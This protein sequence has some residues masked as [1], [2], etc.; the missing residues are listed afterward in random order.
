M[1]NAPSQSSSASPISAAPASA[2][3]AASLPP[4]LCAI[5][6]KVLKKSR[7]WRSER[8]DVE[9]ELA[10]HFRD[11]L[12]SGTAP[13]DLAR[14]FGD[15]VA[16][17]RLIRR[18]KLRNRPLWWRTY[19]RA[20]QVVAWAFLA[21]VAYTTFHVL[22]FYMGQPTLRFKPTEV[23]NR[24]ALATPESKR[25]WP[26]YR[27]AIL[28][29]ELVFDE[30][31]LI[32]TVTFNAPT[33]EQ[34]EQIKPLLARSKHVLELIRQA[35]ALPSLGYVASHSTDH[36]IDLHLWELNGKQ[37]QPPVATPAEDPSE[38]RNAIGILFPHVGQ[39]RQLTRL[40]RADSYAAMREGDAA[41]FEANLSAIL[42]LSHQIRKPDALIT[43]LVAVAIANIPGELLRE[44]LVV[45]PDL[46]KDSQLRDL[47]HRFAAL[48]SA[49][50]FVSFRGE[51]VFF[52]DFLQRSYTDDGNGN[53]RFTP[54]GARYAV[55]IG[56]PGHGVPPLYAISSIVIADRKELHTLYHAT[57]DRAQ[58]EL[59][60]PPWQVDRS[61]PRAES[62]LDSLS[63]GTLNE[64]RYEAISLLLP[65]L[66]K[67]YQVATN[68]VMERDA[69][70]TAIAI[71]LY[72]RRSGELPPNLEA[73]VPSLLPS[74]PLDNADGQP[75]RY[76][77]QQGGYMLY[78][79]GSD[80]LDAGG[81]SASTSND[82]GKLRNYTKAPTLAAPADWVFIPREKLIEK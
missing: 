3:T 46:L 24:D 1:S 76:R 50:D 23:M 27:R 22:R 72:R 47:A 42:S 48:G 26:L 61:V 60:I 77:K 25:A 69:T 18:G 66:G 33:D 71:E 58:A 78:S 29:G 9:A 57:L 44:S 8:A 28:S 12:D 16:A 43:N 11:G 5:V 70:L 65:A 10:T 7:L 74:L 79:L 38:N 13:A 45:R 6:E 31:M 68:G 55:A 56:Q 54:E 75:L 67:S 20:N 53:G 21:I 49:S 32:S 59:E 62:Q 14:S 41:R 30:Q 17:A 73:L 2:A 35:A 19:R 36:E 63:S 64:L 37:G 82:Q 4:D 81:V 51:R 15:P 52:D 40:L 80:K 34:Y 39:L